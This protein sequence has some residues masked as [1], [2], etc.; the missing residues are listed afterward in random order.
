[1]KRIQG[2]NIFLILILSF[3]SC[4]NSNKPSKAQAKKAIEQSF[5]MSKIEWLGINRSYTGMVEVHEL[6][7]Y[8]EGP[9]KTIILGRSPDE[10]KLEELKS[11]EKGQFVAL[12]SLIYKEEIMSSKDTVGAIF[13]LTKSGKNWIAFPG[14]RIGKIKVQ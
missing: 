5:D 8:E 6:K 10:D 11:G 1:M 9:I 2:F 3:Y 4:G 12:A 13:V 7:G 14:S